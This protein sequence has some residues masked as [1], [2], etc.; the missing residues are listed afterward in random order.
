LKNRI[1]RPR[2]AIPLPDDFLKLF[3]CFVFAKLRLALENNFASSLD[4]VSF[5][6]YSVD[7][8]LAIPL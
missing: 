3:L 1:S 8:E 5:V 2:F 7:P 6:V 4:L